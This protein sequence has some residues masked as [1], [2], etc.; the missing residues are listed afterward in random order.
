MSSRICYECSGAAGAVTCAIASHRDYA[1]WKCRFCCSLAVWF[2]FGTTHFCEPCHQKWNRGELR[3]NNAPG[4]LKQ[5]GSR[6]ACPLGVD[7]PPNGSSVEKCL[8]CAKC[9]EALEARS[10]A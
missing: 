8:G 7:H 10:R 9:S 4:K 1:V 2:C 3:Q 5:C 6:E